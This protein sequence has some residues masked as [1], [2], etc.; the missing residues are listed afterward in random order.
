[1]TDY[2]TARVNK[3]S[4]LIA[5]LG[6]AVALGFLMPAAEV[7]AQSDRRQIRND[8]LLKTARQYYPKDN[9]IRIMCNLKT[10]R[11]DG[12]F[13]MTSNGSAHSFTDNQIRTCGSPCPP[14]RK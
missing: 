1:M 11:F 6:L 4:I 10:T 2:R 3:V 13:Y 5:I 7:N 8:C 14:P 12:S 9:G